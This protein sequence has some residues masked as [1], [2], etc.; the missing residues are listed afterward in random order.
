MITHSFKRFLSV[1][2]TLALTAAQIT[3]VF[4]QVEAIPEAATGRTAAKSG[5]AKS[6]MVVAANPLAAEAG[7]EALM[8]MA[9]TVVA[10]ARPTCRVS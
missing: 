9:K 10:A 6:Y 7:P 2:L 3:P 5:T 8:P 4:A 1:A